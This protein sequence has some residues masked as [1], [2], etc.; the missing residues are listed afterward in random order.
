M[1]I[2]ILFIYSDNADYRQ[3][4]EIQ[5]EYLANFKNEILFYFCQMKNEIIN[6]LEIEDN[7]I[8]VKGE[9]TTLNIL[10]KTIVSMKYI[11][12]NHNID[13]LIRTNVSSI[14][15][16]NKLK[17][18][19]DYMPKKNFYGGS[20]YLNLQWLSYEHGIY[21]VSLF[22]TIYA[23]GTCIIFSKDILEHICNNS[24]NLRYDLV[25]DL[26]FGIYIKDFLPYVLE[27]SMMASYDLLTMFVN[28]NDSTTTIPNNFLIYRNRCEAY[29]NN[30][31]RNKDISN[32]KYITSILNSK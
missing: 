32:M 30:E 8:Y 24:G 22:G 27:S 3:M 18:I 12:E 15:N 28:N 1:K 19:V 5:K 25:D 9:E 13:F 29:Q 21:D 16:I 14:I 20:N 2:G 4:L 26:A 23:Q 10:K 31:T 17:Q 6:E 7:F 11:F